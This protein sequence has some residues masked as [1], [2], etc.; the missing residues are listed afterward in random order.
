[1]LAKVTVVKIALESTNNA[2]P[3][4]DDDDDDDDDVNVPKHVGALLI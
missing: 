2:L 1:L 3:D 4:D